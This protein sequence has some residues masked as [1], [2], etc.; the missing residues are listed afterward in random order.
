LRYYTELFDQMKAAAT[1]APV[2]VVAPAVTE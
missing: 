1:P 2:A